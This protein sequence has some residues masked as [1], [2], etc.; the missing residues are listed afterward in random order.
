MHFF[1][2]TAITTKIKAMQKELL[3]L[4]D[5]KELAE[6]PDFSSAIQ[7]LM[8]YPEYRDVLLAYNT[9]DLHRRDLEKILNLA[10]FRSFFKVIRLCKS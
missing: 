1:P 3:S 2:Y 6:S 8:L 9:E 7:K 5:L 10:K 4:S